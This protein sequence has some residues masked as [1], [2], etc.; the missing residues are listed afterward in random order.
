M[1]DT[2]TT[3]FYTKDEAKSST[4]KYED[5]DEIIKDIVPEEEV[6]KENVSCNNCKHYRLSK[7]SYGDT[8]S[9][10]HPENT[11]YTY[12]H[13]GKHAHIIWEPADKNKTLNCEFWEQKE[14][15]L[16]KVKIRLGI[17]G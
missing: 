6:P 15:I 11:H 8:E 4:I 5:I 13:K 2:N 10:K 3:E 17:K 9:C 1:I 12:N 7:S 16:Q 14:S